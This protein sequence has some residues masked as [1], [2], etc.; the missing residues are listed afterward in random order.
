MKASFYQT[1][2]LLRLGLQTNQKIKNFTLDEANK[3][4]AQEPDYSIRD[5][6]NAIARGDYPSWKAYVQIM[7]PEQTRRF[8]FNPFDITK[9]SIYGRVRVC[10]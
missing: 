3:I 1:L 5:L 9:V 10:C 4:N 7:T 6:Y 2:N 8:P